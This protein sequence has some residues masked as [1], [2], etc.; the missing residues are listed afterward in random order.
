MRVTAG[1]SERI[2]PKVARNDVERRSVKGRR[3]VG[4]FGYLKNVLREINSTK[5]GVF[6]MYR[7]MELSRNNWIR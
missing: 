7:L 1:G 2:S 4:R 3:E 5:G 6:K